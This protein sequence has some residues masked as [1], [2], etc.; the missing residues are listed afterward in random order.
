MACAVIFAL[1]LGGWRVAAQTATNDITVVMQEARACTERLRQ[2]YGEAAKLEEIT[3]IEQPELLDCIHSRMVKIKGLV[4]MADT[5]DLEIRKAFKG[6]DAETVERD[7]DNIELSCTRAEKLFLEAQGCSTSAPPKT[8]PPKTTASVAD[9]NA[10]AAIKITP[11]ATGPAPPRRH[12]ERNQQTCLRQE[13]FAV[14]LA[15]AMEL[16]LVE[17]ATS[18]D[19]VKA[20]T[21]MVVEPLGGWQPGKCTTV[22]D[23]YVACV[24]AMKLNVKDPQDPL[25]C[26]E[27][28]REEGLGVDTL[29]PERDPKLDPPYVLDSEVRAFLA[30][31]YAAPLPSSR[32][33]APD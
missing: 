6:N 10:S 25:S 28:L 7:A 26:A 23:V 12:V 22:D 16:K 21:K 13:Q 30:T 29:L 27:A 11:R 24:R 15:R 17:P 2:I 9:T 31:G 32:R 3:P 20:L 14:L 33:V 19:C 18:D 5:A 4:E 8:T 1:A